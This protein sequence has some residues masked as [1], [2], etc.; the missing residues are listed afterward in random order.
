MDTTYTITIDNETVLAIAD[1]L[2]VSYKVAL[3]KSLRGAHTPKDVCGTYRDGT[4][5]ARDREDNARFPAHTFQGSAVP[6]G[7]H[8]LFF[9]IPPG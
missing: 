1:H 4:D 9:Y 8:Q 3:G 7:I 2:A 6:R 5:T